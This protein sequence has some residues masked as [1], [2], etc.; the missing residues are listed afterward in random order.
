MSKKALKRV[1]RAI[2]LDVNREPLPAYAWPGGYPIYYVFADGETWCSKCVNRNAQ[3]IDQARHDKRDSWHLAGFDVNYE[4]ESLYCG[5]C[6]AKIE[7]AYG[8]PEGSSNHA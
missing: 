6:N 3:E 8:E 5:N 7:S 4:D 1:R 2:G